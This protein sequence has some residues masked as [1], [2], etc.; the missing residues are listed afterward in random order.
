MAPRT[1]FTMLAAHHAA[2]GLFECHHVQHV[3]PAQL[4]H[5]WRLGQDCP[6][7]EIRRE[8]EPCG[9]LLGIAWCRADAGLRLW[10]ARPEVGTYARALMPQALLLLSAGAYDTRERFIDQAIVPEFQICV[11]VIHGHL[12]VIRQ[13][14]GPRVMAGL[15]RAHAARA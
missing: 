15:E 9:R 13:W 5:G 4:R 7:D 10:L 3:G 14:P 8:A 6:S 2:R 11:Q 1:H 12:V